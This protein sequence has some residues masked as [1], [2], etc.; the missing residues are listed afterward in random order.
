MLLCSSRDFN[1]SLIAITPA[2]TFN[3]HVASSTSSGGG[4]KAAEVLTAR[5]CR[6]IAFVSGQS[7]NDPDASEERMRGFL[8]GLERVGMVACA[9]HEG[10]HSYDSG[11]RAAREF[12]AASTRPDGVFCGNDMMA[13]GFMDV[14]RETF[15]LIPPDDYQ[16]V[17]YDNIE[18]ANW[19][20]YRLSTIAQ[21]MEAVI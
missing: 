3:S 15:G 10:D 6:N 4:L 7:V 20:P 5:G 14:A 12:F 18:M 9:A 13:M 1:S 21:N 8:A 19:A 16:L 2:G 11:V 17:G